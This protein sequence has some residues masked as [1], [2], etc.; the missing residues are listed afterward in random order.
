MSRRS[1]QSPSVRKRYKGCEEYY[2]QYWVDVPGLEERR[3]E[4]E[5][6]GPVTRMTDSEANRKKLEFISKLAIN[7]SEYRIPSS[8]TFAHALKH[9]RDVFAPRML[10]GSTV[11]I[12]ETRIKTHLETDWKDVP[13]EHITI[14]AVNEWARKKRQTGL[15][16]VTIKDALRTMQRVLSCYSK[17][18]KPPFSQAGLSIPERDKL[19][20]K[21][22]S[23]KKV[24][25]SWAHAVRVSGYLRSM[26]G[27]GDARREQTRH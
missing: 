23:R 11:S 18:G 13:I 27:L 10:R 2:F 15:S 3:R 4:T 1:G 26:A 12:A 7:S 16:W 20:M 8:A 24:S 5:V 9:Y 14:E 17:D 21:I 22:S 25:F 6:L 19:A